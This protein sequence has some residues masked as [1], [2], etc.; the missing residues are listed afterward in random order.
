MINTLTIILEQALMHLPLMLGAYISFSLIKVPD[1]SIESAYVCGA[2]FGSKILAGMHGMPLGIQLPIIIVASLA[3]GAL[4]GL[5]SSLLTQKAQLPHLLSSIITFGI[6]HGINQLI[7]L[8]YVS[9][10]AYKSP[11]QVLSLNIQ[12]PELPFFILIALCISI[13]FYYIFKT[14]LG[15]ALAVYGN[16]P[17]FFKQYGISTT[18]VFVVGICISNALAG[19]SGY[20][21]A[22]S[23]NFIELNMGLGKALL[24]ITALILGKAIMRTKKPISL[25]IPLVGT[26]TYFTLQQLLLKVG[27]NLKYFTAIQALLVLIILVYTYR[28]KN[29]QE[30]NDNLGV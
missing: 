21:F 3:G 6:F 27:F 11:L 9:L 7:S 20:L 5:T 1:L 24:C 8:A 2:I 14:Q 13:V 25:A 30:A 28:N 17:H 10:S 12:N 29:I 4:V 18:Y 16:N 15:Y 22:Q 23:N 26:F 19:L